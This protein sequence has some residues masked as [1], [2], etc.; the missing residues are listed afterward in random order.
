MPPRKRPGS[1]L[2]ATGGGGGAGARAPRN[3][4]AKAGGAKKAAARSTGA[5]PAAPPEPQK[6]RGKILFYDQATGRG[7]IQSA[8]VEDNISLDVAQTKI[9]NQGYVRLDAGRDVT[10]SVDDQANATDLMAE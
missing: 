7:V 8:E 5:S 2:S 10:V 9:L 3:S 6:V 4:A 1:E